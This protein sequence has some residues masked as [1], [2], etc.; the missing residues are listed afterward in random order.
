MYVI[1]VNKRFIA[2][3]INISGVFFISQ[4]CDIKKT[5]IYDIKA[6][7]GFAAYEEYCVARWYLLNRLVRR[8]FNL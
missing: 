8:A 4:I 7:A 6:W 1:Y 2:Y 5:D 3:I